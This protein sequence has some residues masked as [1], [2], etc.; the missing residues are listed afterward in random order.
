MNSMYTR[1]DPVTLFRAFQVE[2]MAGE[3]VV[4]TPPSSSVLP[5]QIP[6]QLLFTKVLLKAL[7]TKLL[8]Y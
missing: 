2:K 6:L 8:V 5:I 1:G 7:R 3:E 4:S